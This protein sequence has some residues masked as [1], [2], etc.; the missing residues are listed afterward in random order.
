MVDK[1]EKLKWAAESE[2]VLREALARPWW[3]L[4]FDTELEAR[5]D[6]SI[7]SL[8]SRDARNNYFLAAFFCDIFAIADYRFLPDVYEI[9]W[10]LRFLLITPMFMIAIWAEFY[11]QRAFRRGWATMALMLVTTGALMYPIIISN[12]PD[13]LHYHI[14]LIVVVLFSNLLTDLRFAL[15]LAASIVFLIMYILELIVGLQLPGHVVSNYAM[16]ML[17]IVSLSLVATFRRERHLRTVFLMLALLDISEQRQA[18]A[19]AELR[20][21]ATLDPLTGLANRRLFDEEYPRLWKDAVRKTQP[22]SILFF[23]LD[24]FKAYNDT[25]GHAKGDEV[26]R[27]F[28]DVLAETAAR[29]PLDLAVRNGGEEF[30]V[31][32]PDSSIEVAVE[33]AQRLIKRLAHLAIPHEASSFG[34]LTASVGVASGQP[35]SDQL[36]SEYVEQADVAVYRAKENGRNRVESIAL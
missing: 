28:A 2:P 9:A 7:A 35:K 11:T 4:R 31:V 30:I 10:L 26:L 3:K 27:R 32:L 22:L 29:R 25:Y 13:A 6:Q 16:V 15:A 5:F 21:L 20:K 14:G 23:D 1:V 24:F 19:N 36:S 17:S 8:Q 18:A 33:I 12:S 34:V